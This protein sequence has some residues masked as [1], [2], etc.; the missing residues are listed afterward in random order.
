LNQAQFAAD[1][2]GGGTLSTQVKILLQQTRTQLFLKGPSSWT[3]NPYE[4]FDFEQSQRAIEYASNNQLQGLQIVVKF[5][6]GQFDQVVPLPDTCTT[7]T[8]H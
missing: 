4:A 6:D 2:N 7:S 1:S 8:R 5:I 3:A